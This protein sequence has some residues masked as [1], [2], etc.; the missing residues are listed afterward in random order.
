MFE[1]QIDQI[2]KFT[3]R[4]ISVCNLYNYQA[5]APF[6]TPRIIAMVA[7]TACSYNHHQIKEK[8]ENLTNE[9]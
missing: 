5:Q 8:N 6:D 9:S 4:Y 1:T 3:R 2:Q 7:R